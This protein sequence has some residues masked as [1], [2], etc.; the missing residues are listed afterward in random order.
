MDNIGSSRRCK[1]KDDSWW[2]WP[3]VVENCEDVT[4]CLL[5]IPVDRTVNLDIGCDAWV[6]L[7]VV[8]GEHEVLSCEATIGEQG[9]T[10]GVYH[11]FLDRLGP[12]GGDDGNARVSIRRWLNPR[13]GVEE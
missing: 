13:Q 12:S 7:V 5:W 1:A 3:A 6:Q 4:S 10:P 11:V 2:D 8:S 9:D